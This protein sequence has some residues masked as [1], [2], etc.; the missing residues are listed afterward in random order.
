MCNAS[1]V[2]TALIKGTKNINTG[3]NLCLVNGLGP[4][5]RNR[6]KGICRRSKVTPAIAMGGN[7]N[8]EV[9]VSRDGRTPGLARGTEY[10][11]T[12]CASKVMGRATVGSTI[13]RIRP[14]LAPRH[15]R[16]ERGNEQ[17]GRSK[18]PVFA[19]ASRS[20]RNIF[21]YRGIRRGRRAVLHIE[22]NAGRK[23]SRT[24]INSNVDL[25]CPRDSAEEKEIKGNYSRALSYSKRVKALVGY[26]EV[27]ELAPERY[28]HLRNFPSILFSGTTSIGS[29]TRLCGRTKGTIATAITFTI[30]VSLP[31]SQRG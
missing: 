28:F 2:S 7:Y 27:H 31:R 4:D 23:C 22:G 1:N 26:K 6:N 25:T 8:A 21:I 9:F 3:A 12:E 13:V 15:V 18:R 24:R 20:E 5:N 16:G 19:L 11:A 10:V 17:V 29:S 30:T 14:I